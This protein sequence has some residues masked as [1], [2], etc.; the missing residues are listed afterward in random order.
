MSGV[1]SPCVEKL[2][3]YEILAE[4]GQKEWQTDLLETTISNG[5]S[6]GV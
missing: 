3:K 4:L 1:G 2:G 6:E 5:W